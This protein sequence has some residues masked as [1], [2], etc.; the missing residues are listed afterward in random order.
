[1]TMI[2][3][4]SIIESNQIDNQKKPNKFQQLITRIYNFFRNLILKFKKFLRIL[5]KKHQANSIKAVFQ[6]KVK[7]Y[8]KY[9]VRYG[10]PVFDVSESEYSLI[11]KINAM[12]GKVGEEE[13]R[14]IKGSKFEKI[15]SIT[16]LKLDENHSAKRISASDVAV[17]VEGIVSLS[18]YFEKILYRFQTA[19][20]E[21]SSE[22]GL[23]EEVIN[24]LN[25]RAK[26]LGQYMS[27]ASR[28]AAR[29]VNADFVI[30]GKNEESEESK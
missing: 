5:G 9:G 3:Y 28:L 10:S 15:P 23:T 16:E 8:A 6:R 27:Y 26:L 12:H 22:N 17:F 19:S 2:D 14:K 13:F 18:S 1:M 29:F 30:Q 21:E 25:Q 7:E 4:Q 20:S 11:A 24:V